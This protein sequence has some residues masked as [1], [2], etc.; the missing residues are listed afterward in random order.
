MG[1]RRREEFGSGPEGRQNVAPSDASRFLRSK[2]GVTTTPQAGLACFWRDRYPTRAPPRKERGTELPATVDL[3]QVGRCAAA[4]QPFGPPNGLPL[5]WSHRLM[6]PPVIP[7]PVTKVVEIPVL[8]IVAAA[9]EDLMEFESLLIRL[10]APRP[11]PL[12]GP[13]QLALFLSNFGTALSIAPMPGF[14]DARPA[15]QQNC[16]QGNACYF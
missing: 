16:T 10:S 1:S 13:V 3:R 4:Q 5:R 2:G 12:H 15:Q 14:S 8:T 7:I 11:K 6:T 9:V